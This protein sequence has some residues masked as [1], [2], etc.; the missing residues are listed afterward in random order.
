MPALTITSSI[1]V[2]PDKGPIGAEVTVSG[3]GFDASKLVTISFGA[4]TIKTAN[5]DAK[6]TFSDKFNVPR[7]ASGNYT[8]SIRDAATF[9]A[10]P[11]PLR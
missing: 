2:S 10:L 6:G 8:I 9:L 3:A 7:V 1:S 5:T 11:L 4:T